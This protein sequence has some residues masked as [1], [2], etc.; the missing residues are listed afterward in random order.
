MPYVVTVFDREDREHLRAANSAA[1]YTYL[2]EN[3]K[4]ILLRGGF[5]NESSGGFFGGMLILDV[6]TKEAAAEFIS[7]DPYAKA[8]MTKEMRIE[9]YEPAYCAPA[10]S[11]K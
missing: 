3:Q 9:R 7:N 8:G 11:W 2:E 1:H 10:A 6:P 5:K 4:I